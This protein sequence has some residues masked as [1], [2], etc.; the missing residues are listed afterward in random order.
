MYV[1]VLLLVLLQCKL[2][3]AIFTGKLLSPRVGNSMSLQSEFGA[4]FFL[5][6]WVDADELFAGVIGLHFL[7]DS[8]YYN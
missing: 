3:I 8:K 7:N 4:I 2:F 1:F 6:A 5:A